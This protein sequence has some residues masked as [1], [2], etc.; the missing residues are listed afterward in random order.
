MK[1][2]LLT[3][4]L[5]ERYKRHPRIL[6]VRFILLFDLFEREYG[7]TNVMDIFYGLCV[8]FKRNKEILDMVLAKRFDIK[9]KSKT[10]KVKWRQE[11][12]FMGMCYGESNYKIARNYLMIN[13]SNLY[14]TDLGTTY[15]PNVFVTD[16]W[17]RNLDDEVKLTGGLVYSNEIRG[18]LE[19]I[20]G[21]TNVLEKWKSDS[22]GNKDYVS[23]SKTKI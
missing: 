3:K 22:G 23:T 4:E 16:E 5:L 8:G 9:R 11:V 7:Y 14:R 20:D 19:I 2:E 21:L 1:N 15:N 13:P 17:L 10:N 18:F 12:A 6:E